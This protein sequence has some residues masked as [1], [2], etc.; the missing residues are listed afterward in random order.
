[1]QDIVRV[2]CEHFWFWL[3]LKNGC[4]G[5]TILNAIFHVKKMCFD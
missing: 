2:N 3:Q 1:M 5:T 4:L